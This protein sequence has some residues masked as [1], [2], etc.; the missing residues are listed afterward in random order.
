MKKTA[1]KLLLLL[2]TSLMLANQAQAHVGYVLTDE[3]FT[4]NAGF[5]LQYLI[6]PFYNPF[7]LFLMIITV[8]LVAIL[9]YLATHI[10]FILK[11]TAFIKK[12][13]ESYK[14]LVGW[15]L[16]LSLGIALIGAGTTGSFVSPILE[17]QGF[18]SFL[19]TLIGF[20]LMTGLLLS[21]ATIL[22][23]PLYLYGLYLNPYLLGNLDFFAATIALLI[24]ADGHPGVDDLIGIPFWSPLT[25]LK[26][27]AP[28]VL[29][30]G[31]GT[32]MMFLA[33]YEKLLN[34]ETAA[35]VAEMYS[36]NKVIPVSVAMWVV[37]AGLIEFAVGL[38]LALGL[39]TR[40]TAAI[41]VAVLSMS[42][43]YFN[44][45]VFSHITLFGVLSVLFVTGG[46]K[47]SLDQYIDPYFHLKRKNRTRK[48][49]PK[50]NA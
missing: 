19:Q 11:E 1:R 26:E 10:S 7:Y 49:S 40:L 12:E 34:P 22:I 39:R 45:E 18:L 28:L 13:A 23:I 14:N 15:M 46:G 25:K 16:R 37:S 8:I 41:A 43:F 47:L 6:T 32:A 42:F 29:R 30:I 33:L 5:N 3:E 4:Q 48:K 2:T 50:K 21:P 20:L 38:L 35:L 27:F 17:T 24:V 9:Y 36:L 31:I 44:E